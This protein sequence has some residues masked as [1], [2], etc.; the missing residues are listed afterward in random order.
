MISDAQF[1]KLMKAYRESH[2]LTESACKAG[3]DRKTARKCINQGPPGAR[4]PP[5]DWRTRADPLKDVQQEIEQLL[6]EC[7]EIK[8][9][10]L[11]TEL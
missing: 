4:R 8:A 10:R 2:N 11:F 1:R 3:M 7:P 5:R 6:G 9:V